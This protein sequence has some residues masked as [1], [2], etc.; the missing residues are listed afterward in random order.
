MRGVPSQ[1]DA[2]DAELARHPGVGMKELRLPG[3]D[4]IDFR[5]GQTK[6]IANPRHTSPT[7]VAVRK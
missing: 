5:R 2:A 6:S 7:E 3:I 1:I 4:Q